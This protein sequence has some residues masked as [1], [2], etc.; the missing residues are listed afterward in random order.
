MAKVVN[1][2]TPLLH[3]G[4]SD[5]FSFVFFYHFF[6]FTVLEFELRSLHLLGKHSTTSAI[7]PPLTPTPRPYFVLISLSNVIS[8]VCM[9]HFPCTPER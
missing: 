8:L 7:P 2:T 6:F 1:T 9:P 4:P 3:L 5:Q